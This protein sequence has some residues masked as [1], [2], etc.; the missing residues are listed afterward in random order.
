MENGFIGSKISNQ[1]DT[2]QYITLTKLKPDEVPTVL[3]VGEGVL[4]KLQQT[5]VLDNMRTAFCAGVQLPN[6]NNIQKANNTTPL[7]SITFNGDIIL[8]GVQDTENFAKK[9]KSEFLTKLSQE[10]YK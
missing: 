8:Q 5:N 6:F 1:D 3:Q 9:I 7:P 10:L 2:F 4:T